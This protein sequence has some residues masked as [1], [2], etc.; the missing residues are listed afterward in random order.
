[1]GADKKILSKENLAYFPK[2][3]PSILHTC[4]Q[5]H[6]A[7]KVLLTLGTTQQLERSKQAAENNLSTQAP[8]GGQT[9]LQGRLDRLAPGHPKT[10]H[11]VT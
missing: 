11:R 6:V 1:M 4:C 10:H 8:W 3:L 9:G 2:S 7:I 5:D